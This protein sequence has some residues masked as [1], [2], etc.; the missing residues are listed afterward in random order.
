MQVTA[1]KRLQAWFKYAVRAE[2]VGRGTQKID[3]GTASVELESVA[4]KQQACRS[5]HF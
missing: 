3:F 5:V 4:T 2:T 1:S